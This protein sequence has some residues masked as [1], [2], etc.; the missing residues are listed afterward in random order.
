[1]VSDPFADLNID[2]KVNSYALTLRQPVWR[3]PT[4]EV[5]TT[6]HGWTKPAAEFGL[7]LTGTIRDDDT[8]LLGEPFDVQPGVESGH[9]RVVAIRFGQDLTT[10][11]ENDALSLRST[12]SFGLPVLSATHNTGHDTA[13]SQFVSWLGQA[14]YIRRLG[15][16]PEFFG[17]TPG[18]GRNGAGDVQLVLRAA[19]QLS[20][21]PLLDVEKFVVGG[22]DTVRGYPENTLVDDEGVVASAELHLPIM[23]G[24]PG[25]VDRLVLVPFFDTGY[26]RDLVVPG[27]GGHANK[28]EDLNSVGIGL[29]FNP[30]RHVNLQIYYGYALTHRDTN[31]P[32]PEYQGLHFSLTVL[33]F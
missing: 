11:T 22:V 31:H 20:N 1:M 7:F 16:M 2:S 6:P 12:F 10:R 17:G 5:P 33:A 8:S 32:D 15:R 21:R 3:R 29:L 18:N 27:N 23:P 19:G 9:S 30:N 4:V 25:E 26:A 13:D 14:Q 28:G 24:H